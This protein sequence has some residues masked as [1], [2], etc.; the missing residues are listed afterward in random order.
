MSH[1][2]TFSFD[3]GLE[4]CKAGATPAQLTIMESLE[5]LWIAKN[6]VAIED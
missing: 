3:G 5:T 6:L 4:D 2:S 1:I